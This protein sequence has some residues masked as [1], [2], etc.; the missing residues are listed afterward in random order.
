LHREPAPVDQAAIAA[1]HQQRRF[2][3]ELDGLGIKPPAVEISGAAQPALVQALRPPALAV[4]ACLTKPDVP[5]RQKAALRSLNAPALRNQA[6]KSNDNTM[7]WRF[8]PV[9]DRSTKAKSS[10]EGVASP[11]CD[12]PD[13]IM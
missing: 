4:Q 9:N 13:T 7:H 10:I 2:I 5:Q 8:R 11:H 3:A 6:G 1:I 12:L